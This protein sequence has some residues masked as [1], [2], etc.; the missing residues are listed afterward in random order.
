MTQLKRFF[1]LMLSISMILS[2]GAC[3]QNGE[4]ESNSPEP[5]T[6]YTG[7]IS[8]LSADSITVSTE[9][10]EVVIP[11]TED[12]VYNREMGMGS[13]QEMSDNKNAGGEKP[14]ASGEIPEGEVPGG[15]G[16]APDGGGMAGGEKPDGMGAGGD[17]PEGEAPDGM[18][19]GGEMSNQ[20]GTPPEIPDGQAGGM[21]MEM[22]TAL[23]VADLSLGD[24]VTVETDENG[25]AASVTLAGG[26]MD[27]IRQPEGM[28]TM[29][30][31]GGMGGG[32]GGGMTSGVDS[33]DALSEFISDASESGLTYQ[34]IADDENAIHVYEGAVVY[35]A[36]AD[37]IRDSAT[38]TG[39]DN[40]SFYG[41]GAAALVT[42]GTLTISDSTITTDTAGGAGVFAYGD[43]VAYVMDTAIDTAQDTAGGI[44]VAGGGTLYAWDLTVETDGESSAAIRSDRGSGTMVVDG[45]SYTSNGVGSPAIYSA[46]DIT[47]NN[48]E[49]VSTGSE[50]ICIE[51]LNSIRL[52]DC[53][54]KGNMQDLSQNDCTW[55]VILYQSMSGDSQVGNSTFEMIGGSLTAGNG[56]M[57]YTTNTESTFI[58]S[59]V[60]ITYAENSEFFLKC[61]GNANQRGWGTTGKNGA[62]CHFTAIAQAMQGNV[63]WDSISELDFYVLEGSVLTGA[64]TQDE[65]C[66]GNGGSGYCKV[67]IDAESTWVVTGDSVLTELY[68][69]GTIVDANGNTVTIQ[70][71]D[72][73]VYVSGTSQYTI[74]VETYENAVD[75]SG[76]SAVD[77]WSDFAIA[78]P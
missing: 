26:T 46:A 16:E 59:G 30:Q 43:G 33:Y 22:N 27:A 51:G 78:R 77:R 47:V 1:A 13:T 75:V 40:S 64:A 58:L 60:E 72:G 65:T 76:A 2:L 70:S 17:K 66:A 21:D 61:T 48:A 32:M 35:I 12:T 24:T 28:G 42:N 53:N 5:G 31:P 52:F 9:T 45:G 56:G 7:T 18:G 10:G 4:S 55:N 19:A 6:T 62:D 74:T 23:S 57:F 25:N 69:A 73:T 20:E 29:Q 49:L 8:A 15:M 41:I 50:A 36:N 44:H 3:S 63:I 67:Y 38:S 34:S 54:L 14:G 11:L 71:A 39:G 68:C 37:I